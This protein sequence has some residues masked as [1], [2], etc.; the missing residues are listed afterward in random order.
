MSDDLDT[1][2][3]APENIAEL[4]DACVR[5]VERATGL[6]LD[7]TPET[8]P[9]LDHWVSGMK[10]KPVHEILSLV[11]PTAGAYFGEVVRRA[12]AHVR[13]RANGDDFQRWR[14]EY[15]TCFLHF[16]PIG[17]AVEAITL[18][19]ADGWSSHFQML[20]EDAD[21][22]S[23]SLAATGSVRADDYY[24][25]AVRFEAVDQVVSVLNAIAAGRGEGGR[26][27]GPE[28]YAAID[29]DELPPGGVTH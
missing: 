5:F 14:L 1:I 7:Y 13:W 24:R 16:N 2:A 12:Q 8:L 4:A 23:E 27:F 22:V 19:E 18:R 15:E 20:D 6:T 25:F 26:R 17:V 21:A 10:E 28:I 29:D 3:P 9:F 11:A